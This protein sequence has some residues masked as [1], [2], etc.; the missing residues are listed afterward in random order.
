MERGY[1]KEAS[2]SYRLLHEGEAETKRY[3]IS[4]WLNS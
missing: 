4:F 1:L 3:Y 2:G